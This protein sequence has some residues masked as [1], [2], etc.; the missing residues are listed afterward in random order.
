VT[1]SGD[2]PSDVFL[3]ERQRR[4]KKALRHLCIVELQQF[5]LAQRRV[6]IEQVLHREAALQI[7]ACQDERRGLYGWPEAAM[8]SRQQAA[9][10]REAALDVWILR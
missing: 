1:V 5:R 2:Q 3:V 7:L 10:L 4:R 6:R 9:E 8:V